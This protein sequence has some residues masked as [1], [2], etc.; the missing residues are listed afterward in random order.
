MDILLGYLS[1]CA[2]SANDI[3]RHYLAS[4]GNAKSIAKLLHCETQ[5]SV[6]SDC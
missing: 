4:T 2:V 3:E 5:K 6:I 1:S